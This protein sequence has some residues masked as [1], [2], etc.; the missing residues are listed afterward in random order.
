MKL[1]IAV[2]VLFAIG[3]GLAWF[4]YN[5]TQSQ[6]VLCGGEVMSPADICNSSDGSS[7]DFE[8]EKANQQSSGWFTVGFGGVIVAI[9]VVV[10][11]SGLVRGGR[12]APASG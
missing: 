6:E 12:P 10:L 5:Q 2:L 3:G 8:E 1:F 9:G 11:V 7:A 4:G